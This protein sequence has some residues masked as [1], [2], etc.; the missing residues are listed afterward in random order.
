MPPI[1]VPQLQT[2]T[3]IL[4]PSPETS[5][6]SGISLVLV[7]VPRAALKSMP[8]AQAAALASPTEKGIS[9]GP[10]NAPLA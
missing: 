4:A 5:N 6:S 10:V 1:L 2:K 3:P 8:A 7:S 9:L